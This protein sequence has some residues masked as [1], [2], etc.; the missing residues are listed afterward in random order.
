MGSSL[1]ILA[2]ILPQALPGPRSKPKQATNAGFPANIAVDRDKW[3]KICAG[4]RRRQSGFANIGKKPRKITMPFS[5]HLFIHPL[6]GADDAWSSYHVEFAPGKI[7]NTLLNHLFSAPQFAEFDRRHPWFVLAQPDYT[8][9]SKIG[10]CAVMVFPSQPAPQDSALW[11]ALE[12]SLRQA[13]RKVAVLAAPDGKLPAIG[14]WH[15]LLLGVS[16]ARTLPPYSLIGLSSRTTLVVTDVPSH[17]DR[18]WLLKNA[19]SLSSSEFLLNRTPNGKKADTTRVK[20]LKLLSLIADDAETAE[21]EAIFRQESKLSYSL[22]RLVNSAAIAPRSPITSFA[23]AINLLGRRQLQ[24]WL[25]LLV[26]ADPNDGQRPNPLLQKAAA[27]GRLLELLAPRLTP[28]P[29]HDNLED[30]AF[31]IGTF[32]LLD[33]LLNISMPEILKQL[34]LSETIHKA[35]ADHVGEL[36][37]LLN[38]ISAAEG[39]DLKLASRLL[40]ELGIDG[41]TYLEAELSAFNWAAKIHTAEQK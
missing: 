27:R 39:R 37:R 34:L 30:A 19:C 3:V 36:G 22:L 8:A 38:A 23:Q 28:K 35:L 18:E 4:T 10:E 25:Q 1:H 29:E 33:V 26:Y 41:K 17:N 9:Q 12:T 6:L 21:L 11:Q 5:D 16:H 32:S 24:R 7:N 40:T 13:K 20:L 14:E 15:Y 2:R 31:M